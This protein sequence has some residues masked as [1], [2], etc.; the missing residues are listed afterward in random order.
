GPD[1]LDSRKL[2]RR[3]GGERETALARPDGCPLTFD[4]DRYLRL[5]R[6]RSHDVEQLATRERHFAWLRKRHRGLGHELDFQ[7]GR[8]D[9]E[10]DSTANDQQVRQDGHRLAP[11]DYT[12]DGLERREDDFPLGTELHRYHLLR[13]S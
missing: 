8:G 4:A 2:A 13:N 12:D 11:L 10:L 1:V 7:I 9:G 3:Q 5:L 6:Q